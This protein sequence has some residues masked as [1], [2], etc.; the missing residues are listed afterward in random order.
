LTKTVRPRH[1]RPGTHRRPVL[2]QLSRRSSNRREAVTSIRTVDVH[3]VRFPTSDSADGSDAINRGDYSATYVEL[4]TDGPHTGAGFTFT[5]GRCRTERRRIRAV[6]SGRCAS[7]R[8]PA[9]RTRTGAAR[10]RS[11]SGD[12]GGD[13]PVE[14]VVG[15]HGNQPTQAPAAAAGAATFSASPGRAGRDTHC[16]HQSCM[17]P[18]RRRLTGRYFGSYG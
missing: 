10:W 15:E 18:S 8:R 11:Q 12:L 14:F 16:A 1:Q 4:R 13:G 2:R 7:G 6:R 9:G 3:D 17:D 5:N